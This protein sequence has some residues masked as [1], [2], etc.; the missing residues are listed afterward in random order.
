MLKI[1]NLFQSFASA[2]T[3]PDVIKEAVQRL[4][5]EIMEQYM[6]GTVQD[7]DGWFDWWYL[8]AGLVTT[9]IFTAFGG[10]IYKLCASGK[11]FIIS[12]CID[13]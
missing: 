8:A 13:L 2:R 5:S 4:D 12:L 6:E 10:G 3:I 7:S 9:V 11:N 1:T